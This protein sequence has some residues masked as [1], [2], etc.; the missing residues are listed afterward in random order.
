[1]SEI[2]KQD[3]LKL[4][5]L[6]QFGLSDQELAKFQVELEE[7]VEYVKTLDEID[8]TGLEP[9][10]Q[11]TGLHTVTR[12]DEVSGNVSSK[13]LLA[14]SHEIKDNQIVVKRVLN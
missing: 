9:S 13:D 12:K 4:A 10:Y 5:K 1:M 2:S 11:V 3:V 14:N 8:V 6:S 7:I